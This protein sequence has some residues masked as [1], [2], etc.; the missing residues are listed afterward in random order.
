MKFKGFTYIITGK[1]RVNAS[2][3]THTH[4]YL[5]PFS[6]F[7]FQHHH[8]QLAQS[9]SEEPQL[10]AVLATHERQPTSRSI[11]SVPPGFAQP[12]NS[13]KRPAYFEADGHELE[14]STGD[15]KRHRAEVVPQPAYCPICLDR[16]ENVSS[17]TEHI[18]NDFCK[19]RAIAY[20]RKFPSAR[21][22]A[23]MK[24]RF[25]DDPLQQLAPFHDPIYGQ[26]SQ[27]MASSSA[28]TEVVAPVPLPRQQSRQVLHN[29]VPP[30]MRHQASQRA[31]TQSM[32]RPSSTRNVVPPQPQPSNTP[33]DIYADA[34]T[35][36]FEGR[37]PQMTSNMGPP[38]PQNGFQP[39]NFSPPPAPDVLP[40][41]IIRDALA[42]YLEKRQSQMPRSGHQSTM[43]A[44]SQNTFQGPLSQSHSRRQSVA[45]ALAYINQPRPSQW[46]PQ[47]NIGAQYPDNMTLAPTT[48]GLGR[49][50]FAHNTLNSS[51]LDPTP[52]RA[53][54]HLHGMRQTA[55]H[56]DVLAETATNA[57]ASPLKKSKSSNDIIE[58]AAPASAPPLADY[59]S[60]V[61]YDPVPQQLVAEATLLPAPNED[62]LPDDIESILANLD[63]QRRDALGIT[64]NDPNAVPT[65]AQ[66]QQAHALDSY[67]Q[68]VLGNQQAMHIPANAPQFDWATM[69]TFDSGSAP[70]QT[71]LWDW[72]AYHGGDGFNETWQ[73]DGQLRMENPEMTHA[74]GEA[75]DWAYTI[76]WLQLYDMSMEPAPNAHH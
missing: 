36:Y 30:L 57:P 73:P 8:E 76:P 59:N 17:R 72:S 34:V 39:G 2:P 14:R 25:A 53:T 63:A 69:N 19:R 31:P 12:Q 58:R 15:Y 71:E 4:N 50:P 67:F 43:Q 49:P 22:L 21:E 16:F 5:L 35:R 41:N 51:A 70:E 29:G 47:P 75:S 42:E 9:S 48:Q 40:L 3:S 74:D 45:Q 6:M 60:E 13:L 27:P 62:G 38:P 18:G 66:E 33:R 7:P 56:N 10:P 11:Y 65:V 64:D 55:S 46:E 52:T 54:S 37:Q 23:S 61:T 68:G 24:R 26:A 44:P 32:P 20:G 1:L 28:N